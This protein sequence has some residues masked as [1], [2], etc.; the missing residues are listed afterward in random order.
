M[1]ALIVAW[2]GF[3]ITGATVDMFPRIPVAALAAALAELYQKQLKM[4]D[5]FL[6]PLVSGF[7]LEYLQ[8]F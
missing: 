6:I 1:T 7:V 8:L 2:G 4:D 3:I 5:N